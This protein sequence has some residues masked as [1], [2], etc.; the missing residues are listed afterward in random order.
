LILLAGL[1]VA[2][3]GYWIAVVGLRP[4][5][6]LSVDTQRIGRRQAGSSGRYRERA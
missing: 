3:L 1:I 2:A 4:V 6:Q 5:Q